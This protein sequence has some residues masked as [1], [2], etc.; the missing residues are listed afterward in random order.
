MLHILFLGR[1][2]DL[3][4]KAELKVTFTPTL[5]DLFANFDDAIG[6]A[7]QSAPIRLA[8]NGKL[9]HDRNAALRD[10]DEIAFFPPVSGG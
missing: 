9:E 8:I 4:G 3:V 7:L 5:G 2:E 10:G 1:L 6:E